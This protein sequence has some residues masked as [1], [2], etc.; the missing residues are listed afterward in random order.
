[1]YDEPRG[2]NTTPGSFMDMDI[3][4]IEVSQKPQ[5]SFPS[6]KMKNLIIVARR[7]SR[8]MIAWGKNLAGSTKLSLEETTTSKPPL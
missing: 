1:L 4:Q 6:N 2:E 5:A 7:L 8:G 3:P